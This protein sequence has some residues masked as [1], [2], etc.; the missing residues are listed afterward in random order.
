MTPLV[1]IGQGSSEIHRPST[2]KHKNKCEA[3]SLLGF[4]AIVGF[5]AFLFGMLVM[6]LLLNT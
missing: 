2:A 6:F 1:K 4:A 5:S 3:E